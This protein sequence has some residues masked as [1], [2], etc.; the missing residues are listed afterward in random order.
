MKKSESLAKAN[1]ADTGD[2][3]IDVLNNPDHLLAFWS[4]LDLAC[5]EPFTLKSDL[6]RKAAFH[7]AVCASEG[8]ISIKIDTETYSNRW[9]LTAKGN[10]VME[11]IYDQLQRL[12]K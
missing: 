9:H 8:L 11:E 6:A 4:I 2:Q 5:R 10:D 12:L 1:W 3:H 7:V